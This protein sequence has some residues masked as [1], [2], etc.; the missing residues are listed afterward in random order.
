MMKFQFRRRMAQFTVCILT[1]GMLAGWLPFGHERAYAGTGGIIDTVAGGSYGD[2]GDGGPAVDAE[3]ENPSAVAMDSIG[4]LYIADA[5]NNKIRKV[6]AVTK[7]ISTV[8]GDGNYGYAGDGNSALGA[9]FRNPTG[10]AVDD[11]GN[12]YIADKYNNRIRKIDADGNISTI[13]GTGV[14]DYSGDSGLAVDAALSNPSAVAIYDGNLYIADTSNHRIRLIDAAGN[15]H[16]VAGSDDSG[17]SGDGGKA[18]EARLYY[19]SAIAVDGSGNLYIADTYNNRIRKVDFSSGIGIIS[20]VAGSSLTD[21]FGGDG[22]SAVE[23]QLNEPEGVAIDDSGNLYISDTDNNRIRKVIP[24]GTIM[25][26][27]GIGT[28]GYSGDGGSGLL[29]ELNGP[30]GITLDS[31][32]NLIIA[33]TYNYAIR[34]QDP[35]IPSSEA[36]LSN[37]MLSS[38][39]LSPAFAPGTTDYTASVVNGISSI[40]VTPTTTNSLMSVKVNGQRIASGTESGDINLDV[41]DNRIDLVVLAEDGVTEKPYT[42]IVKREV[43]SNANLSQL[44]LSK[45]TLSPTFIS[46]TTTYT[47][48]ASQSQISV[49]PTLSDAMASVKVNGTPVVSG[50]TSLPISLNMG[51]ITPIEIVV[52]AQNGTTTKS[53]TINV[54]RTISANADLSGLLLS[55]GTLSPAFAAGTTDYEAS[56]ENSVSSITVTPTTADGSAGMTVNDVPVNSGFASAP[57]PLVVGSNMIK[58]EV[59][60]ENGTKRL[61]TVTVT[62]AESSNADLTDLTLSNGELI[63]SFVPGTFKT[64]VGHQVSSVT[65]TPTV[66]DTVH[67]TV[68]ISLY[69]GGGTLVSGPFAVPSGTASPSLPLAVGSNTIT[70]LVT[71]Q[72]GTTKTY[73]VTA[74]RGASS[75]AD[76]SNLTLSS[77]TLVPAFAGTYT[78]S[79]GHS[80][81]SITVTPTL[82]EAANASVTAS[83]YSGSGTLV[84]G[85]HI[86]LSG[87]ASPALPLSEGNNKIEVVVTA[88]DGATKIYTVTVTRAAGGGQANLSGLSLSSGTLSPSFDPDTIQYTASVGAAISNVTVTMTVSDMDKAATTVSVYNSTGTLTSGP[89]AMTSGTAAFSLPLNAGSNE[90]SLVVTTLGGATKTYKIDITR[91]ASGTSPGGGGG[92]GGGGGAFISKPV[93]DLNGQTLDPARIDTK[94][95]FVTLAATPKDGV[96]YVSVPASILTDLSV[97]NADFYLEITTPYAIYQVPVNLVS[98]IPEFSALLEKNR[99]KAEDVSFKI[100]LTDKSGDKTLQAAIASVLPNGKVLGAIVDFRIDIVHTN[101]GLTIGKEGQFNQALTRLIPMPN[102]STDLPELW[103]AFRYNEMN[104]KLEFVPAKKVKK[105][106]V[107]YIS[108]LSFTNSVYFAASKTVGFSDMEQHWARSF[109]DLAAVKGLVEG[110]GNEKYAPD[111][112]MTRAEFATLLVR[113]LGRGAFDASSAAYV[114]V[115]PEAWYADAVAQAK[116]LGLLDIVSGMSFHPDQPLTRE[117]MASMLAAVIAQGKLP[118]VTELIGAD[119]FKD[120]ESVDPAYLEDVRLMVKLQIMTG[121][122]KDAFDPQGQVTRAQAA[123]VFIRTLQALGMVD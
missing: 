107:V 37:I 16:T 59:T 32:G 70:V 72:D 86:V 89:F 90:I 63:P 18:V 104:K 81:S 93:I 105:D 75:N 95:P 11:D 103:G 109:V 71:A 74:T 15:I 30:L 64:S 14:N 57:L 117:E 10:V 27:A 2:E 46:T 88:Q 112:K 68:T 102:N 47:A 45:G 85:P 51:S 36:S 87:T 4:N 83:V 9:Q 76:L 108:I 50:T 101:T 55:S 84:G 20:T 42:I 97:N 39:T 6:N 65:V 41:G 62:R 21:G 58:V 13:A 52:T 38:G 8:A 43:S 1:L 98:L 61:Y 67:A 118:T 82:S 116:E 69:A 19:P 3:L 79:V 54:T 100:T 77:G 106:G 78:A 44:S 122:S 99:L 17:Y 115:K 53:Y 23:A 40:R 22:G 33:D 29:A 26:I 120:I 113:S 12:V 111:K 60:A 66:A 94:K 56:V 92:G 7:Q 73:T 114:D 48:T 49:T 5:G 80:V 31:A 123:T 121:V 28:G 25:T 110:I 34:I 35:Y 119:N 24:S 96:T 91:A